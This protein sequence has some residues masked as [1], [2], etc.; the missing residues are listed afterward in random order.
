MEHHQVAAALVG[1]GYRVLYPGEG[2]GFVGGEIFWHV[3][4][5]LGAAEGHCLTRAAHSKVGQVV[6]GCHHLQPFEKV[7]TGHGVALKVAGVLPSQG[8]ELPVLGLDFLYNLLQHHEILPGLGG[9]PVSAAGFEFSFRCAE[10][11][12]A[13]GI[14]EG[15]PHADVGVLP[16]ADR[17]PCQ[18][19]Q[20][21]DGIRH[22]CHDPHRP[23]QPGRHRGGNAAVDALGITQI[24]SADEKT[25]HAKRS[26][27]CA[28][29][30][31]RIAL[32]GCI[33]HEKS[34]A[35]VSQR[36]ILFPVPASQKK[37]ER[38]FVQ[39]A[40]GHTAKSIP[41]GRLQ[42][43]SINTEVLYSFMI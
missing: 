22:V 27:P 2:V 20:A 31:Y 38:F 18:Q 10:A 28:V 15:P 19:A 6:A 4:V 17:V 23:H 40:E 39:F 33:V 42:G 25:F 41:H 12:D 14:G 8:L 3:S 16:Q 1:I 34:P 29:T 26:F 9:I 24:V 7:G 37:P 36:G 21:M 30:L 35:V 5:D 43:T 11:G 32:S 13:S